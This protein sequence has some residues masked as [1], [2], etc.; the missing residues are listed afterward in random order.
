M[1]AWSDLSSGEKLALAFY[2]V[3]GSEVATV[4]TMQVFS[5]CSH[6]MTLVFFDSILE[7][8]TQS[9]FMSYKLWMLKRAFLFE[10]KNRNSNRVTFS[11]HVTLVNW[12]TC[13]REVIPRLPHLFTF[14]FI[15][16]VFVLVPAI[17]MVCVIAI[18]R[19]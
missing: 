4:K 10:F 3:S 11:C 13:L 18:K 12:L 17:L 2:W 9:M 7:V 16:F 14:L 1:P 19:N 8:G 15:F 5:D 6:F